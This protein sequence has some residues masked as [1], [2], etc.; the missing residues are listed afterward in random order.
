VAQH[1]EPPPSVPSDALRTPAAPDNA[2]LA[3]GALICGLLSVPLI[4]AMPPVGGILAI[5]AIVL[6]VMATKRAN[7]LGGANKGK[8]ITGIV[9]GA[10]A[11][12]M[13]V[14]AAVFLGAWLFQRV[15]NEPALQQQI[16]EQVSELEAEA[17]E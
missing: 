11:L 15:Q 5:V 4:F 16:Q 10:L 17:S 13:F 3:I 9:S 12:V 7:A 2:Q 8:A 6:G 14:A 1:P